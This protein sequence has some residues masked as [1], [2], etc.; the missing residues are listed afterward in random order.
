MA[1]ISTHAPPDA[2]DDRL[3]G[4]LVSLRALCHLVATGGATM[5]SGSITV[6]LGPDGVGL[7]LMRSAE[8]IAAEF[9]VEERIQIAH[10]RATIHVRRRDEGSFP[11]RFG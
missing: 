2:T 8:P 4:Q 7:A 11:S 6:S 3:H 9:G 1:T 10:G 5:Q